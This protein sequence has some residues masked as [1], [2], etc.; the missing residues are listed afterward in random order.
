ME[1]G[2]E[3]SQEE[4]GGGRIIGI[5]FLNNYLA[6]GEKIIYIINYIFRIIINNIPHLYI[7]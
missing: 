4:G 2:D 1:M 3:G 6:G 7:V 5:K